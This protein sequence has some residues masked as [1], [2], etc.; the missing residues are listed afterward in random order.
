LLRVSSDLTRPAFLHL[1]EKFEQAFLIP[2]EAGS[3]TYSV[4]LRVGFTKLLGSLRILVS[5]CLTFSPLPTK[6]YA[7]EFRIRKFG[8]GSVLSTPY[9]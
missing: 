3:G 8:V 4:L 9:S 6:A 2:P 1:L 7:P 5:S